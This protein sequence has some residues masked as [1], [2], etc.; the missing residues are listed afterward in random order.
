MDLQ[1]I[2]SDSLVKGDYLVLSLRNVRFVGFT[3]NNL[4][5]RR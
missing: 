5:V 3:R 2:M 4:L 1:K